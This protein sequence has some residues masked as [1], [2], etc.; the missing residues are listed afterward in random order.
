LEVERIQ[1]LF[2][3]IRAP[4]PIIGTSDLSA[5]FNDLLD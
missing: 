5:Y 1:Y 2:W 4:D 3:A